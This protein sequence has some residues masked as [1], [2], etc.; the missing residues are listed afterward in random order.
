MELPPIS[1]EQNEIIL[2]LEKNNVVV[3]S[4]AG[5]G[6]TTTNLYIAKKYDNK[7]I[8]L[9][10]YNKKLRLETKMKT[11][12]LN[13]TNLCVHTYH[14]FCG[15]YYKY[16]CK[17]DTQIQQI[18]KADEKYKKRI[19]YDIIIIDEAQDMTLL[20]YELICK[21]YKDNKKKCVFCVLG[22]KYQSIYSFNNADER[23]IIYAPEIFNYNELEW[24]RNVLSYSFRMPERMADFVNNC[25][26]GYSRIKASKQ[27]GN[28]P[29]YV[30]C[31][32]FENNINNYTPLI[33]LRMY[34]SSGYKPEEIIVLA[35]SLKSQ[36]CPARIFEN[37]IKQSGLQIPIYVPSSDEEQLDESIINNKLLFSTFHQ[38]KGLERKIAIVFGFDN[39]Y[40]KYYA[41]TKKTDKCTNELYVALTRGSQELVLLHH[42]KNDY[43][44]FLKINLLVNYTQ[45]I[46]T[47][48]KRLSR[49]RV[50]NTIDTQITQILKH[51]PQDIID[52]CMNHLEII[53][54]RDAKEKIDIC[55]KINNEE[56]VE[57][58]SEINGIAIPAYFEL[59][60]KKKMTILDYCIN[61]D[62]SKFQNSPA[63]YEFWR[64]KKDQLEMIDISNVNIEQLFYIS[65]IYSSLRS[66]FLFKSFQ[67]NKFDWMDKEVLDKCMERMN[68]LNISD[69]VEFEVECLSGNPEELY[70]RKLCG[71]IDCIDC[72]NVYEFKCTNS[73]D[74]EHY[75]QLA[76]YMYIRDTSENYYLYNILTDQLDKIECSRDKLTNMIS[77]LIYNKYIDTKYISD[78]DFLEKIML[79]KYNGKNKT[80][81]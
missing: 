76:I 24:K 5:S 26:L 22:D 45:V 51:L 38:A 25:V 9:L 78:K 53:K 55:N 41:T 48:S 17:D 64:I 42:K 49:S 43:L 20:Y 80:D 74:K 12:N 57:S 63:I 46:G 15:K 30:I 3:D 59:L 73:L 61:P 68:S 32:V 75:L 33:I 8:L 27:G 23:Y 13:I 29:K 34:L 40:Y 35:Y 77:Y 50:L 70:N 1:E 16:P 56:L 37:N 72:N 47:M 10:T 71:V 2:N 21:I 6:K 67:I 52:N 19:R 66:L 44:P 79:V 54:I 4:V 31:D 81:G 60:K 18:I 28:R 65:T 11:T 69:N 14:S 36:Q 58:V 39:S 62:R 7:K